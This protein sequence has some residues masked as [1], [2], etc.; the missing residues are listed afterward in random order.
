VKTPSF[1]WH[2]T[3]QLQMEKEKGKKENCHCKIFPKKRPIPKHCQ[4]SKEAARQLPVTMP[5]VL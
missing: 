5:S 1:L 4:L 2:S 3:S